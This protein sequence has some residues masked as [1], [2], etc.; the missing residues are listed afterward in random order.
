MKFD[1]FY[2]KE[3]EM[4]TFYR[5]P[6]ILII[7]D[8][9]EKMDNETKLLYGLLLDR[10][11]LS[12]KN[13]WYDEDKKVYIYY[14]Q[15]SLMRDLHRGK[16]KIGEMLT[17]L[18]KY[19]LIERIKGRRTV[20][21]KIYV[22]I[23]VDQEKERSKKTVSRFENQTSEQ[24][25]NAVEY[26][27]EKVENPV[28]TEVDENLEDNLRVENEDS[29]FEIQTSRLPNLN[30][31][32]VYN[33]TPNN[34]ENNK[35][36]ISETES[37]R[38][39]SMESR[40]DMMRFEATAY[41]KLIREN[42]A[43]DAMVE[44]DPDNTDMYEGIYELVYETVISQNEYI[45]IASNRYPMELVKSK[46]LKLDSTHIDYVVA[47]LKTNTSKIRNIKKYMLAALF[48][49][50]TTISSYYQAEFNNHLSNFAS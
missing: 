6:K 23:Y 21:D 34:T 39:L 3:S 43:I 32:E 25:K 46:F 13:G 47:S 2:G 38:I 29:R 14:T 45:V 9:F 22:K 48:N 1:Y 8:Y 10:M 35:T 42:L 40:E 12:A 31:H 16:N 19:G 30:P 49:A 28:N 33:S 27:S 36:N 11:S 5:I 50:P 17:E 26:Y 44:R 37:N 41:G 20:P 24:Y 18:E 15:K 7:D 4:M